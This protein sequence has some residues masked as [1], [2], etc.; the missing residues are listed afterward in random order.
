[1]FCLIAEL[2]QKISRKE[3][4]DLPSGSSG[5]ISGSGALICTERLGFWSGDRESTQPGITR[6]FLHWEIMA[7][8]VI[9]WISSSCFQSDVI[10]TLIG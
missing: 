3:T 9:G 5:F 1:M 7:G 8:H 4:E 6:A 10:S 2:N